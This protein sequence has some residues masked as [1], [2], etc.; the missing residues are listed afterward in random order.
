[1]SLSVMDRGSL[2]GAGGE[3]VEE[4]FGVMSV[5]F[6]LSS[7]DDAVI[8]RGPKKNGTCSGFSATAYIVGRVN[9]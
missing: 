7:P 9:M 5:G 1:M 3:Y 8:W 2:W 6:L 4:N